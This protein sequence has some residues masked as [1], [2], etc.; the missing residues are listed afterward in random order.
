MVAEMLF[1]KFLETKIFHFL[2]SEWTALKVATLA[3]AEHITNCGHMEIGFEKL[4][5]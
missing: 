3:A 1:S 4:I 5:F 2:C